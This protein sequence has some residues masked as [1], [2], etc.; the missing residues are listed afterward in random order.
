MFLDHQTI[1]LY[2]NLLVFHTLIKQIIQRYKGC[3]ATSEELKLTKAQLHGLGTFHIAVARI[4]SFSLHTL[5]EIFLQKQNG[6]VSNTR[7]PD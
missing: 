5:V 2:R 4:V 6:C 3:T 1:N 7:H